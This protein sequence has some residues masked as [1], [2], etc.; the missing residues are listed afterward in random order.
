MSDW[1]VAGVVRLVA[2]SLL[3]AF[4]AGVVAG[5]AILWI[6]GLFK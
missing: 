6:W 1:I 4:V 3:I 2:R 5:A